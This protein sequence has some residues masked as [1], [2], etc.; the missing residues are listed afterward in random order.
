MAEEPRL[1]R[2]G[3]DD[4]PGKIRALFDAFLRERGNIPNLYRVAAHRPA[5][6]ESLFALQRAVMGPGEVN[7]SLKELLSVRVSHINACEY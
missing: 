1:A 2:L 7:M 6:A 3:P 4:V 5:I